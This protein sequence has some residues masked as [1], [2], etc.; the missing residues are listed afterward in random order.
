MFC[1]T[2]NTPL[3]PIKPVLVLVTAEISAIIVSIKI[4]GYVGAVC[5]ATDFLSAVISIRTA[6]PCVFVAA[7]FGGGAASVEML[8]C[9][10]IVPCIG[11]AFSSKAGAI[12]AYGESEG[13]TIVIHDRKGKNKIPNNKR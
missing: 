7:S 1:P 12:S 8:R 5:W 3:S 10:R 11:L 9:Y 4:P 2:P 13:G 6:N